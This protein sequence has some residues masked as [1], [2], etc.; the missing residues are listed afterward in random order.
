MNN[1]ALETRLSTSVG[2]AGEGPQRRHDQSGL[3]AAV[4]V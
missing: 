4:A 1:E 3:A 2:A